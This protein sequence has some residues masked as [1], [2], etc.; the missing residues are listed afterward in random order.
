MFN[1]LTKQTK[2]R[3]TALVSSLVDIHPI[4]TDTIEFK[5]SAVLD[6]P[7]SLI[8]LMATEPEKGRPYIYSLSV[9]EC[10][11]LE[12]IRQKFSEAKDERKKGRAYARLNTQSSCFYVGSS[13]D[14]QK[15]CKEHMGFGTK[16]TYA[17]QL[18]HWAQGFP[19]L[20]LRLDYAQYQ[21][22]TGQDILQALEDTLWDN[23]KPMF[24]RK[25][26]K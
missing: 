7:D 26:G 6:S 4:R 24:G 10:S 17:L 5:I 22:G 3:L 13:Y 21:V 8:T 20:R 1:E 15:R 23:L 19:S 11:N 14:F 18:A 9:I 25:G 16:S 2:A 12:T